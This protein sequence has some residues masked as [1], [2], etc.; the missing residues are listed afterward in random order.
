MKHDDK[1][2]IKETSSETIK[3]NK[4]DDDDTKDIGGKRNQNGGCVHS[5]EVD[6]DTFSSRRSSR[7]AFLSSDFIDYVT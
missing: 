7:A 3:S 5:R 6:S 4:Q 1:V 2:G